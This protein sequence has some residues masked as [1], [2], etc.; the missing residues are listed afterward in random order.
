MGLSLSSLPWAGHVETAWSGPQTA[1]QPALE[2]EPAPAPGPEPGQRPVGPATLPA[3]GIET[4][5]GEAT[6]PGDMWPAQWSPTFPPEV[7]EPSPTRLS[8]CHFV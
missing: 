1:P 5:H 7:L 6:E 3:P 8:L 4:R 2:S